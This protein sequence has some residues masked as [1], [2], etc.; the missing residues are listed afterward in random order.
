M[1][2][3]CSQAAANMRHLLHNISTVFTSNAGGLIQICSVIVLHRLLTAIK[4]KQPQR[5][6]DT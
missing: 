1:T 2:R 5:H 3:V 4:I 6:T